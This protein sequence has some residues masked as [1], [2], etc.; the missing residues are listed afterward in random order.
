MTLVVLVC[1]KHRH[2][3]LIRIFVCAFLQPESTAS[4]RQLFVDDVYRQGSWHFHCLAQLGWKGPPI[5][6]IARKRNLQPTSFFLYLFIFLR[7]CKISLFGS[8]P[9]QQ[10]YSRRTTISLSSVMITF[11]FHS[12]LC[13]TAVILQTSTTQSPVVVHLANPFG[14]YKPALATFPK[15]NRAGLCLGMCW[16]SLEQTFFLP[17]PR[18]RVQQ[19]VSRCNISP[20]ANNEQRKL[21]LNVVL[22]LTTLSRLE[23]H[24]KNMLPV[25]ALGP[26]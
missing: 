3:A 12:F 18:R 14:I 15:S 10:P 13:S 1:L 20:L 21:T 8:L 11:S 25:R 4:A 2:D 9:G 7:A 19:T 23:S 16:P 5:N 6:W 22:P 17:P 24:Q 26:D